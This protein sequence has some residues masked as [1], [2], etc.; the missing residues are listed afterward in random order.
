MDTRKLEIVRVLLQV[1]LKYA[2]AAQEILDPFEAD[3]DLERDLAIRA[4]SAKAKIRRV[5]ICVGEALE[6]RERG[7]G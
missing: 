1:A 7:D 6:T 2:A 4:H 3:T 5:L